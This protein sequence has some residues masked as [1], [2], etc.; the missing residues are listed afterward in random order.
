MKF[1]NSPER[2]KPND[3][4][5]TSV[6]MNR[7]EIV[8]ALVASTA[9]ESRDELPDTLSVAD[10]WRRVRTVIARFG[11]SITYWSDHRDDSDEIR[12]WA[13]RNVDRILTK[14]EE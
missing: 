3:R 9:E 12:D 13:T 10:L 14:H 11:E 4:R 7:D 5:I 2:V 1:T 8:N 6:R